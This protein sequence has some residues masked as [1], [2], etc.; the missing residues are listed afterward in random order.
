VRP[1]DLYHVG[2]VCRDLDEGMQ[3]FRD[4]A[5][6]RWMRPV[7]HTVPVWTPAGVSDVPLRMVYSLD[8]PRLELI[9]EVPGTIWTAS[10]G[11]ELHHVGY[12]VD[13]V[14]A[15]SAELAAQGHPLEARSMAAEPGFHYHRT[16]GVRTEI[17]PRTVLRDLAALLAATEASA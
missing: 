12:L 13:D 1:Q 2:I 6:C 15:A 3:R 4:A 8:E 11:N 10:G 17:V 5:G 9:Q 7:S 16:G 14:V